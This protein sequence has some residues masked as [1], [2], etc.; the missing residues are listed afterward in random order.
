[1][2]VAAI[3]STSDPQE[4]VRQLAAAVGE[5]NTRDGVEL[6]L[7]HPDHVIEDV[8]DQ[9]AP[10]LRQAVLA[11][12]PGDRRQL[13]LAN[14]T[15]ENRRQWLQNDSYPEETI[16]R[17]MDAPLAVF[18]ETTT[19]AEATET[20]RTLVTKAFVT[21]L[22][23]VDEAE[24]LIGVVVMR[25]MLLGK[26]EQTL[27]E[28]MIHK[29]FFLQPEMSI[30]DAMKLSVTK[31]FPVYPVGDAQGRLLG[32]VRGTVLFEAQ[33][34]ELSAQAGTMV[35][36]EKEERLSTAW[37]QSLKFR[38]PWLQLNLLTAFV[39]AA[40][41]GVFEGTLERVVLLA[42]FLPV[43]AGQSGNTG[44]Q[45]LA[46]TLRGMTLGEL[47][48]DKVKKL[49]GK[50]ALLGLCN[51]VMVGISAG[52]GMLV[53]ALLQQRPDAGLLA[54]ITWLAMVFSCLVSGVAGALVP[55]TLK[56][57]GADPATASSI[58][59]T[60]ATDVVSMGAFLGLATLLIR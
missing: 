30:S 20:L 21:Y 38:H 24:R 6:L 60:T 29:P 58:F 52:L 4:E 48:P 36:V 55:L 9:L 22:W 12:I 53:Y 19:I 31:H 33:A 11:G 59:L 43:L 10:A 7:T 47:T 23:V 56:K 15:P 35:G 40:V 45:A 17:L 26:P 49:V 51:G 44:C 18:E 54:F 1:M 39:A 57:L 2:S 25:E 13:V 41:V 14:A 42:V 27:G 3:P 28:I 5:K 16:G 46:V 34:F 32:T 37:T 8:L 50:E